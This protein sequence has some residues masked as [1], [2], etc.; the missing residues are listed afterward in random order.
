ML[1]KD[2]DVLVV[3]GGIAGLQTAL[4]LGDQGFKVAI[5]EKDATI[6]GQNDP[7]FQGFSHP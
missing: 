2:F 3:G 7:S 4:D 6:G 5:V 1:K